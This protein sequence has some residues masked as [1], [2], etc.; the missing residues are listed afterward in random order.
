[1]NIDPARTLAWMTASGD[2]LRDLVA[3]EQAG[4]PGE[5]APAD[6]AAIRAHLRFVARALHETGDPEL[7]EAT[8]G[9]DDDLPEWFEEQREL[10]ERHLATGEGAIALEEHLQFGVLPGHDPSLDEGLMRRVRINGW[11]RL[12]LLAL[13]LRL[14]PRADGLAEEVF[15]WTGARQRDLSR[16]ILALEQRAKA[17]VGGQAGADLAIQDE[18][19]QAA[20]VQGHVRQVVEALAASL[21]GDT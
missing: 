8:E 17:A 14:G 7:A 21:P 5:Q 6:D 10:Y 12:F 11:T 4:A 20:V 16:L 3:G 13:E 19:N 1:M 2:L 15:A 18:I 9:L